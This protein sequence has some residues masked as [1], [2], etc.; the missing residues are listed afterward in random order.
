MIKVDLHN[1]E[2]FALDF[3]EGRLVGDDLSAFKSFL[4]NHPEIN[5]EI[6]SITSDIINFENKTEFDFK[7]ELK[8][9]ALPG[10]EINT[11]NYQTYF[12][13]FHEGDLSEKSRENVLVFIKQHPDKSEEFNSFA[14]LKF[15]PDENIYFPLKRRIKKSTPILVLYRG[16]RI[17]ASIVIILGLSWYFSKMNE[18]K[19]QYTQRTKTI[20]I[21]ET[22]EIDTDQI[23][24][25]NSSDLVQQ[26]KGD[27]LAINKHN[28]QTSQLPVQKEIQPKEQS[29]EKREEMISITSSTIHSTTIEQQFNSDLKVK[30][31]PKQE[32]LI[33]EDENIFKI[34]LPKLF[35]QSNK[36]NSED[37]STALARAKINF[38]KKDKD[39]DK[40]TYVDVGPFKV[41]KKKGVSVASNINEGKEGL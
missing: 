7:T 30:P 16:L 35:K 12:V 26:L 9:E 11:N 37:E 34:K 23:T 25:S 29:F 15:A 41:Y 32:E 5:D 33:A 24:K 2:A 21:K 8:K 3:V 1:Y 38:N 14:N 10:E 27:A 20:E 31:V 19:P 36:E 13:A 6:D 4:E 40:K 17:A 18:S 39:P 22:P 28:K